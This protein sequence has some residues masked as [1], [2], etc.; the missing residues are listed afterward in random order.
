M[1]GG[2]LIAEG[3]Y[4]CIFHPELTCQGKETKNKS[5]ITKL[6]R[7][8]FSADNEILIGNM[9][10]DNIQTKLLLDTHFAPVIHS[11]PLNISKLR[12]LDPKCS[13]LKRVDTTDF[14]LMKIRYIDS[15]DLDSFI[16][17]NNNSSFLLLTL[18]SS[19]NH[20]LK[21][22]RILIGL[23]IVHNDLKGQN[24]IY[25]QNQSLPII[26]DFG[27]SLPMSKITSENLYNYFYIYAPEY[28][29]WPL[30]VHLLN[31]L[32]HITS[33]PTKDQLRELANKYT[34]HNIALQSFSQSFRKKFEDLCFDELVKYMKMD[35][36]SIKTKILK[37]WTTWDNYSLSIIYLKFI[38]Y[39][40]RSENGDILKNPFTIFITKL[41]L[42]N[43]HPDV[44]KR[45]TI[46]E[47][48]K[49]FNQFL[50]S[51]KIDKV[52][53]FEEL[54]DRLNDSKQAINKRITLDQRNMKILTRKTERQDI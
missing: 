25:S 21:S 11:C 53:V 5:Y 40:I 22:I 26:I 50:Y 6:Q 9:I 45:H 34:T 36:K 31:L 29:I 43:I 16:I 3:G 24:I 20:I 15:T 48:L 1:L 30:E 27:L 44:Q 35:H 23:N 4:G 46:N 38:Y 52:T 2:A 18:I 42:T 51:E 12:H 17:Q 49:I 7:K 28:Y 47:T 32:L 33:E 10:R 14:M 13:V 37:S 39:I 8:D 54:V 41:L 19:F